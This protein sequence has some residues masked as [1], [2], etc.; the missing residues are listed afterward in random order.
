MSPNP[1]AWAKRFSRRL[2]SQRARSKSSW[3]QV[4]RSAYIYIRCLYI[5]T[6]LYIYCISVNIYIL[7][8]Y[9]HCVSSWTVHTHVKHAYVTWHFCKSFGSK[10]ETP[11]CNLARLRW[12]H[13]KCRYTVR[14]ISDYIQI[15]LRETLPIDICSGWKTE[16]GY[17][18][19]VYIYI[20]TVYIYISYIYIYTYIHILYMNHWRF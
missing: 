8:I 5:Y 16:G 18:H 13:L 11:C 15:H 9:I 17:L 1:G 6:I 2:R 3:H 14:A 10:A 20:Y 7:Y 12:S 19:T 4:I